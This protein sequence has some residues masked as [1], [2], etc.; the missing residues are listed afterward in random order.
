MTFIMNVYR[1]YVEASRLRGSLLRLYPDAGVVLVYDEPRLKLPSYG[2]RWTERYLATFMR[3]G[4][5][6]AVKIDPDTVVNARVGFPDADVF[7]AVIRWGGKTVLSGA[8]MGFTRQAAGRILG[9]NLLLDKKYTGNRYAY[10]W[11]G[12]M[13][14]SQDEI[15][16]DVVN[17]L[18]LG[19][20]EWAGITVEGDHARMG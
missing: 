14:S 9:S 17:V 8:V 3:S 2:G 1:D 6:V 15:V 10:P 18:G 13:L 12:E 11:H 19:F 7:S 5:D 16:T 20:A 4:G